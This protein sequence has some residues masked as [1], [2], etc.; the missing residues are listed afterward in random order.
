VCVN[1]YTGILS[2]YIRVYSKY[3]PNLFKRCHICDS[4]ESIS[5]LKFK[6]CWLFVI[7]TINCSALNAISPVFWS[8]SGPLQMTVPQW[9]NERV[10]PPQNP[11]TNKS[12]FYMGNITWL[13]PGL[14]NHWADASILAKNAPSGISSRIFPKFL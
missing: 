3:F 13:E 6:C 8:G 2:C 4:C 10:V 7:F 9:H 12:N 14:K 1:G 5:I 11:N